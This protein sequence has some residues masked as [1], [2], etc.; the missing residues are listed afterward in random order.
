MP[1]MNMNL[2]DHC[3]LTPA[4]APAS[5]TA[6]ALII[7]NIEEGRAQG[8]SGVL[9]RVVGEGPKQPVAL[10]TQQ[11]KQSQCSQS[12]SPPHTRMTTICIMPLA[13]A[14]LALYPSERAR[15]VPRITVK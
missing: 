7:I 12:R 3:N 15:M 11:V 9:V 6:Q 1:N 8:D 13:L 10:S 4:A 5:L 2:C 14:A